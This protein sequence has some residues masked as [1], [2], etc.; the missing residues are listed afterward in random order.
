M[1]KL[2][3]FLLI[4]AF[5]VAVLGYIWRRLGEPSP[6]YVDVPSDKKSSLDG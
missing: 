4:V 3:A 5:L 6:P 1:T 2:E